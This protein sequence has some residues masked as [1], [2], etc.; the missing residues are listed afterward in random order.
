M[1]KNIENRE[2]YLRIEKDRKHRNVSKYRKIQKNM[3]SREKYLNRE[4]YGKYRKREI[5]IVEEKYR[6][7]EKN[8]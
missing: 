5:Q 3:E 8:I 1:E 6:K 4:K 2:K 7:M